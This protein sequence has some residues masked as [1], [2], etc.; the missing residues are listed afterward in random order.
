MAYN[1]LRVEGILRSNLLSFSGKNNDEKKFKNESNPT[2]L[3]VFTATKFDCDLN[4]R[5]YLAHRLSAALGYNFD[6]LR[7]DKWDPF[8]AASNSL[9]ISINYKF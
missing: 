5:Y 6:L 2:F 9:I 8:I 3:S 1:K 4:I 7:I